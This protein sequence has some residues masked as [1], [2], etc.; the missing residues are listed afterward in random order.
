MKR[1]EVNAFAHPSYIVVLGLDGHEFKLL[2]SNMLDGHEFKLLY[3]NRLDGH[4]FKLLY[5]NR[6]DGHGFKF[7]LL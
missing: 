5:S 1:W 7:K 3:S 6:L 4:G 2:Y